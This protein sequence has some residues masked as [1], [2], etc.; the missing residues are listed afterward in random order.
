MKAANSS[1]FTA[2]ILGAAAD[3]LRGSRPA[4]GA[5]VRWDRSLLLRPKRAD[6]GL[7]F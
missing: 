7:E 4:K 2:F 1:C 3:R 6:E 5:N